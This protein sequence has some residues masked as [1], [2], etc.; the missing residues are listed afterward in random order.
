M[1]LDD[2][3]SFDQFQN[4]MPEQL[5][6]PT[7][8][9]V[10]VKRFRILLLVLTLIVALIGFSSVLKNTRTLENLTATGLVRGRV[11]DENGQPF[12]G[13]VFILGT[14]LI[15]ETDA[16]GNFELSRVPAGNRTLVVADG[17]SGRAFE[18][19]VATASEL[20]MGE[21]RFEPTAMPPN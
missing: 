17:L 3:P 14:K 20:Q 8:P 6:K 2:A 9:N 16:D 5:P 4:G 12:Q 7:D 10:R 11:V 15:T 21:I 19:Q 1:P 13:E 18:I